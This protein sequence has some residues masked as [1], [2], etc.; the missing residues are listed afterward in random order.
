VLPEVGKKA[1]EARVAMQR[2]IS[3]QI[4]MRSAIPPLAFEPPSCHSPLFS[5]HSSPCNPQAE[6]IQDPRIESLRSSHISHLVTIMG[7][8]SV[9]K[10]YFEYIIIRDN[11]A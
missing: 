3:K 9:L 6:P 11:M 2:R 5:V 4:G 1:R 10:K 8:Q 7:G